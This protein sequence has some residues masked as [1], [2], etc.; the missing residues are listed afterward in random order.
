VA[1]LDCSFI[2]KSGHKTYGLGK[3]WNGQQGQAEK[4]L[5]I[6]TLAMVDVDYNTAYHVSSKQTPPHSA[7]DET[8]VDAYIRHFKQDCWALHSNVRYVVTDAYYT[9]AAITEAIVEQ[10]FHQIGK[11]RHDANL[12]Y[13]YE[14]K[15]KA[16][17]RKRVY[18]GKFKM[19]DKQRLHLV[20]HEDGV[21]IYTAVMNCV[22][23]K[24]NIRLVYIERKVAQDSKGVLLF[25]TDTALDALSL[26]RYYQARFQIE[27]LFRDAKQFTGLSDCQARSQQA[28]DN[29]FNASFTA[30]N[31]LKWQD[32]EMSSERK[33][34]SIANWK[35]RCF[36]VL[37][38]ER[39]FSNSAMDLS[40][41]KSNQAYQDLCNFGAIQY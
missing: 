37:F 24:K 7:E 35:R 23:L 5:E 17:G 27:F 36:N 10:G 18:D 19:G 28:L 38:M 34:I 29:H 13:L 31:L 6:S 32:R 2:K 26:Y 16:K 21:S 41:I 39:I 40:C 30:L 11:L 25:S 14:G 22:H 1:A 33:P 12:R 3:Y 9:K 15:Q 8:R 20:S 4:G